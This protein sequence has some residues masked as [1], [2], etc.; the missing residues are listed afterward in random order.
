MEKALSFLIVS[1]KTLHFQSAVAFLGI[2]KLEGYLLDLLNPYKKEKSSFGVLGQRN[3][4][5]LIDE[6]YVMTER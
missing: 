4:S 1:I 2:K 5:L 6:M 3:C